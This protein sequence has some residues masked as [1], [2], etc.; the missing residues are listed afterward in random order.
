M[1]GYPV[2]SPDTLAKMQARAATHVPIHQFN[3]R[4]SLLASTIAAGVTGALPTPGANDTVLVSNGTSPSYQ[5]LTG[6]NMAANA[7]IANEQ[8]AGTSGVANPGAGGLSQVATVVYD[9]AV[10]GG[11]I[12]TIPLPVA[13][14]SGALAWGVTEE[15]ITAPTSSGSTGTIQLSVPTDGPLTAA[16]TANGA[17]TNSNTFST[18]VPLLMT[19]IRQLQVVIATAALTAGKIKYFIH[20]VQST[21]SAIIP[22]ALLP[23][24][25]GASSFFEVLASSTVTN[26]GSSVIGQDVG[27]S[28]GTS[29][30]GFPPG[31]LTTG[32]IHSDDAAAIAAQ[33]AVGTSISSLQALATTTDLSGQNLG[34]MTLTAGVYNFS[35]SAQLTGTLR[36]DAQGNSGAQFV[37]KIGSTLTTAS[38]SSVVLVNGAVTDNVAFVVGSSATLGTSTAFEGNILA[39]AS[40]TMNT[41]A[42]ILGRLLAHTG[43]VTLSSNAAS[44]T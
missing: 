44:H 31:T 28:P 35:S 40:I 22:E 19:A 3:T 5:L 24:L 23:T 43:A 11:A 18:Q 36:L 12:G 29:V 41:D 16:Q 8:L 42:T 39:V 30:T 21:I 17:L 4:E 37:F 10:N 9:F 6:A 33:T 1:A 34:G 15:V 26:T 25:L 38:S 13:L 2:I 7:E 32:T 20:Y 27:V 14:P